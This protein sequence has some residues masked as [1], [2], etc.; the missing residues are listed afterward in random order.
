V[1]LPRAPP[2]RWAKRP[3][4]E[5][6]AEAAQ[7]R[8]VDLRH[9]VRAPQGRDAVRLEQVVQERLAQARHHSHE[10]VDVH[11]R[12]VEVLHLVEEEDG[13]CAIEDPVA[14]AQGRDPLAERRVAPFPV[15]DAGEVQAHAECASNDPGELRLAGTGLPVQK[16]V[17]AGGPALQGGAEQLD[18]QVDVATEVGIVGQVK[19]RR[20]RLGKQAGEEHP[21][22]QGIKVDEIQDPR[23]DLDLVRELPPAVGDVH[24]PDL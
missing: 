14:K 17:D 23:V 10:S 19:L 9:T 8:G 1:P 24:E 15:V 5:R 3:E 20:A 4:L 6:E 21:R 7:E 11:V 12:R 22:L 2:L 18:N 13:L 16:D